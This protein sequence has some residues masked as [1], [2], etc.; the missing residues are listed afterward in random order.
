MKA[1]VHFHLPF[2]C[3][4]LTDQNRCSKCKLC[5]NFCVLFT[6]PASFTQTR[7]HKLLKLYFLQL[8][9]SLIF[10]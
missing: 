1:S 5:I 4:Y 7:L 6:F 2:A 8:P 3:K 10:L 9:T